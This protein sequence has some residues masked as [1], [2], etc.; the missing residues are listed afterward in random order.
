AMLRATLEAFACLSVA[1]T[2]VTPAD[3]A[4]K[5]APARF[6]TAEFTDIVQQAL[7]DAAGAYGAAGDLSPEATAHVNGAYFDRVANATVGEVSG[8]VSMMTLVDKSES[9]GETCARSSYS[10]DLPNSG[11]IILAATSYTCTKDGK[12]HFLGFVKFIDEKQKAD[13]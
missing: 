11:G 7:G 6:T 9:D 1:L 10:K 4:A 8:G 3:A 13:H 2:P 5:K 12:N